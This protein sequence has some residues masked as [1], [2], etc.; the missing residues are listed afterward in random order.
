MAKWNAARGSTSRIAW[1]FLPDSTSTT[2]AGKTALTNGSSGLN[3]SVRREFTA[4]VTTYSGANI[5]TIATLGT[6][7]NPGVGKVNFKE[8]DSTNLPGLYELHFVDLLFAAG[9]GSRWLGGM[10]TASGVAP[11]PFELE[12]DGMDAQNATTAGLANLDEAV[13]SRSTYAGG[14]VASVTAG[15]TVT[16]NNDKTGYALTVAEKNAIRD[17]IFARAFP[18]TYNSQTFDQLIKEFAAVLL[19]TSSGLGTTTAVYNKLDGSGAAITATVDA[20]GNR[21]V[22]TLTP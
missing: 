18:A 22:V 13:S 16:T 19:G 21:S 14:A 10:V 20:V 5:G 8:V 12:L 15:V 11:S 7:A 3:I 17:A 6:W 1:V 4:A 2:G 9:D